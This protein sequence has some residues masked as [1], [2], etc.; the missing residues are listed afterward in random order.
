MPDNEHPSGPSSSDDHVSET[1]QLGDVAG[2]SV[3]LSPSPDDLLIYSEAEWAALDESNRA[4]LVNAISTQFESILSHIENF[5][6][7]ASEEALTLARKKSRNKVIL[8]SLTGLVA[9]INLFGAAFSEYTQRLS[10]L[11]GSVA[12]IIT[13]LGSVDSYFSFSEK[14]IQMTELYYRCHDITTNLRARWVTGVLGQP[15]F[16]TYRNAFRALDAVQRELQQINR[17]AKKIVR[18]GQS[19]AASTG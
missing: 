8:I 5:G 16:K 6:D 7:G 1:G 15:D 9:F 10:L 11:S 4:A 13:A 18:D 19:R 3:P 2:A 17:L 12:I 14:S